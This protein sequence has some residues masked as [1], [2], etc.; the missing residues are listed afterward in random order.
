MSRLDRYV[1]RI[2]AGAFGAGLL[3]FLFL[4]IVMDLLG[5]I[6]RYVN[7]GAKHGLSALDLAAYLAAYYCQLLPVLFTT[8][9]PFV[10]VIACMFAVARLQ[11]ANEVVPMLFTGRSTQRVLRPMLLCGAL[12]GL[13]MAA[14]WQWMVPH[15]G[16]S[17]AEAEDFLNQGRRTHKSLIYELREP[18]R[19]QFYAREYVPGEQRLD[20]VCP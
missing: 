15:V 8:I 12:A 11:G 18:L 1:G 7:H 20:G 10:T 2:V 17:L 3:F 19:W 4:T 14:C 9:T 6:G 5:N 16:A 13:G